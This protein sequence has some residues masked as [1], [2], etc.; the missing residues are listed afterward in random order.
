MEGTQSIQEVP[1]LLPPF[2]SLSTGSTTFWGWLL[3]RQERGFVSVKGLGEERRL[4]RI[5]KKIQGLSSQDQGRM[6]GRD[7]KF[8]IVM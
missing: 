3:A 4:G 2:G 7:I 8:G 5:V 6:A 1:S